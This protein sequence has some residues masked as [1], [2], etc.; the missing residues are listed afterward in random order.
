MS[1]SAAARLPIP[2]SALVKANLDDDYWLAAGSP[3]EDGSTLVDTL[4]NGAALNPF[5]YA[6]TMN[7]C[8][9][10]KNNG[11]NLKKLS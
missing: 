6:P 8:Y 2:Y 11:A 10:A 7:V 1:N 9:R 3:D 4:A 5:Q